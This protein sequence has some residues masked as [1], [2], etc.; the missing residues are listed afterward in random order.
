MRIDWNTEQKCWRVWQ[1]DE[2]VLLTEATTIS[3][4]CPSDLVVTDGGLRGY[5]VV[6]GELHQ[7]SDSHI[8]IREKE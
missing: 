2:Q 1:V 8:V 7:L 3:I 4:E 5:L 6:C